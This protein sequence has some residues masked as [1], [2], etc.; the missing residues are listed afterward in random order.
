MQSSGELE[1]LLRQK[2]GPDFR[3]PPGAAPPAPAPA[4]A[5]APG[6]KAAAPAA[7]AAAPVAEAS[8]ERLE[9]LVNQA[10]VMLFMKGSPEA[11]R[12][13]FSRKVRHT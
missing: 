13:G 9:A 6:P 4:A 5:A 2:L 10:P 11:P 7:A 12:C 8:R 1:A 3:A